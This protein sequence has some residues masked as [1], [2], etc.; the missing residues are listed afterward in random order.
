MVMPEIGRHDVELAIATGSLRANLEE[1]FVKG[2]DADMG[3]DSTSHRLEM[4]A[5][6]DEGKAGGEH[7]LADWIGGFAESD[8]GASCESSRLRLAL[9]GDDTPSHP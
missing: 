5:V 3:G 8:H 4:L 6:D 7:E 9:Y 1:S 2:L